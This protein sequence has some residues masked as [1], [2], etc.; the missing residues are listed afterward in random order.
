PSLETLFTSACKQF[1]FM[2]IVL[3]WI[4]Q[5][6]RAIKNHTVHIR[7]SVCAAIT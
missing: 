7:A 2:S 1:L 6:S 5:G 4:S 3:H